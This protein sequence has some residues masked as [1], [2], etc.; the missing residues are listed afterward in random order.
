M[1]NSKQGKAQI[2][3][4]LPAGPMNQLKMNGELVNKK[5]ERILKEVEAEIKR[6][7]AFQLIF[8]TATSQ[9]YKGYFEENRPLNVFL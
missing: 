7:G 2:S 1:Q 8:P 4:R 9:I 5:D 3:G 6:K